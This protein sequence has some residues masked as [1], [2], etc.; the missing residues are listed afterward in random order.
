MKYLHFIIIACIVWSCKSKN[1]PTGEEE[2]FDSLV[3][4]TKA[5]FDNMK[6]TTGSLQQHAFKVEVKARGI[7]DVPPT[8]RAKISPAVSGSVKNI[9]IQLGDQVQKGQ[10]LLSLEGPE[11][12]A[13]QQQYL[14]ISGQMKSLQAEYERQKALRAEQ[15]ASEK[16]F[17]E[18][19]SNYQKAAATREGLKQQL[20]LLN[21]DINEITQGHIIPQA[22]LRAP[23][24]GDVT[25]I[26][27]DIN[28]VAHPGDIVTEI[29]DTRQLQLNLAVFEKDILS[30]KPGQEVRF[31]LPENSGKTFTATV[32]LMGKAI[33]NAN[34]TATVLAVPS[35]SARQKLLAGMYIDATVIVDS[36]TAWTIPTDALITEENNHFVLL[37]EKSEPD[38]YAFRKILVHTGERQ[39]ELTE[40]MP[41]GKVAPQAA[42]LVK[43]AYDAVN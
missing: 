38:G 25:R 33:D 35:D 26:E 31:T 19:E 24:A 1:A 10:A 16:T 18:A 36:R 20:L 43:G 39:G 40:V 9:F 29:T 41:G 3:H 23:I 15:I 8:G 42:L 37:L 30:V 28:M 6:M 13:L 2:S 14:E 4:I 17:L 11:I 7:V 34:R 32:K 12:I 5:Q 27:A 22:M 21:L